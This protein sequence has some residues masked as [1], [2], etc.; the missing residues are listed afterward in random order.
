MRG[1]RNRLPP[2]FRCEYM[3]AKLRYAKLPPSPSTRSHRDLPRALVSPNRDDALLEL[4]VAVDDA[5]DG[6]HRSLLRHVVG[7]GSAMP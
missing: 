7:S 4:G 2:S 6:A 3:Y 1:R 5:V